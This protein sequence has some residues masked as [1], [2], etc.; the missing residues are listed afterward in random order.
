MHYVNTAA[1]CLLEMRNL[2]ARISI[3]DTFCSD[4]KVQDG[5][6]LSLMTASEHRAM[7]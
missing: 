1:V 5:L 2:L 4:T 3:D 6:N 7:K